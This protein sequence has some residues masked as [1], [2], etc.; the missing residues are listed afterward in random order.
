MS[1]A[2]S[3]AK[4]AMGDTTTAVIFIEYNTYPTNRNKTTTTNQHTRHI[5]I[6]LTNTASIICA[7]NDIVI[8]RK[9][10][11]N[12]YTINYYYT[13]NNTQ[14]TANKFLNKSIK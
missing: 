7:G 9:T 10:A 11:Q 13:T 8:K 5:Q 14:S 2:A 12:A 3:S 1:L 6:N 4:A